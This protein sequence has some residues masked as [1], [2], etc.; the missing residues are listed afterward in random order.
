MSF[1]GVSFPGSSCFVFV[2]CQGTQI[3]FHSLALGTVKIHVINNDNGNQ[4][5]LFSRCCSVAPETEW[6]SSSSTL[7]GC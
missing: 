6:F 5:L 7:A 1:Q 4:F 2:Q 3:V